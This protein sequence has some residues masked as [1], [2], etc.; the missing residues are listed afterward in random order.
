MKSADAAV[1]S[2]SPQEPEKCKACNKQ[3]DIDCPWFG[4]RQ[5]ARTKK[6]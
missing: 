1:K 6:S 2:V 5:A 4:D 3:C